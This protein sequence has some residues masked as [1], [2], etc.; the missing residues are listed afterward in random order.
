MQLLHPLERGY[1]VKRIQEDAVYPTSCRH[2]LTL[3]SQVGVNTAVLSSWPPAEE[4]VAYMLGT[5]LKGR[6]CTLSPVIVLHMHERT[7]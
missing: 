4:L 6:G 1:L 2:M 7:L 3:L 5:G